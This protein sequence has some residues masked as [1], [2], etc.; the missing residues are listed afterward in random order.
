MHR[1]GVR[2]YTSFYKFAEP[3]VLTIQSPPSILCPVCDYRIRPRSTEEYWVS[4]PSSLNVSIS[5]LSALTPIHPNDEVST[6]S[7][8]LV[9][10]KDFQ[11][12]MLP[13][14]GNLIVVE[15]RQLSAV[16]TTE[17]IKYILSIGASVVTRTLKN[18]VTE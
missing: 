13:S 11:A 17:L 7:Y 15:Y 4:L 3:C 10:I 1:T 9:V 6:V 5:R 14:A 18:R 12:D 2:P 16:F 8:E